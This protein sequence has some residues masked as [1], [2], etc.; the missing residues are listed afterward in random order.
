MVAHAE[1]TGATMTVD[2]YLALEQTAEVKHE[3]VDGHVYAMSGGTIGHDT[4]ANNMRTLIHTH[5]GDGPCRILGPDIR[6]RISPKVYYYPDA[7][8][9]C[10]ETIA[11]D[12][13]EVTTPRLVIEVL[14]EST[15]A[16]DRGDKF[17]NYQT[18]TT[19]QEYL[20][21][22]SRRRSVERFRRT[23]DR[24]WLYQRYT[25][26][27]SVTLDTIGLTCPIATFYRLTA[28]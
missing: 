26:E 22:D 23:A 3:Y 10:G 21:I 27:E 1:S 25:P 18:L 7:L 4:I 24:L 28:L 12:A 17:A 13:I 15:E 11:D 5:L 16:N 2:E 9:I 8:V 19:C 14:S 20:L 6:L